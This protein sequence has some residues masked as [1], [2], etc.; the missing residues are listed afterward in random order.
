M[1]NQLGTELK[2]SQYRLLGLV[3][4]GQFGRVFCAVHRKTGRLVALKNLEQQRFSTHKFLRELRFLLSLQHRN[5]VT[6]KAL[7]H[8]ATGRYL[9]MDYCEG[10]TLRNLI[11][12]D[13]RLCLSQSLKLIADI[14]AGLEHA[15]DRSIVH[16][17]IKPENI[18]LTLQPKGWEARISDFGI[19]RLSQEI[20]NHQS[21]NTGSPAYMAPERFYGQYSI[22]SDVYSVGILLF[23]LLTGYRPFS[24]TPSELMSAH[25]NCPVKLPE[26][27]PE[28]CKP[29][30]LTALQK[31][32]ARR[33]R[34]IS[35]MRA[36]VEQVRS[37][38]EGDAAPAAMLLQAIEPATVCAFLYQH[39][40]PLATPIAQLVS[41]RRDTP[42]QDWTN[43]PV[44]RLVCRISSNLLQWQRLQ[45]SEM[46]EHKPI[47]WQKTA[48]P[49]P[50]RQLWLCPQGCVLAAERSL[51]WMP[52]DRPAFQP[53]AELKQDFL[54]TVERNG[55]W[56]AIATVPTSDQPSSIL[57]FLRLAKAAQAAGTI[58]APIDLSR[59]RMSATPQ[60]ILA[61]DRR[62]VAIVSRLHDP[63]DAN[64][65]P[66]TASRTL[67]EIF[68]RRGDRLGTLRLGCVMGSA[69]LTTEPYQL[70]AIDAQNPHSILLIDLKP[71]RV[72]RFGV[73]IAPEFLLATTWGF[74]IAN[75]QGA[76]VMLNPYGE[77]LG[78][79][80]APHPLTAIDAIDDH[81]LWIATWEGDRGSFYRIDL[82]Q[83]NMDLLF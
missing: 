66:H 58:G 48:L 3:G 40:E 72:A 75:A 6:C 22:A 33:Y 36:E 68:T 82:K 46:L 55:S 70:L 18:L 45:S 31:L 41:D 43:P 11:S 38:L 30:L 5:I 9:V 28:I 76:I 32:P 51:Y 14:L 53:I 1:S 29:I 77:C 37:A 81:H 4:Q 35:Q 49:R 50:M 12:G 80:Q 83:L 73:E 23:E 78:R 63:G 27:V 74:V 24:G 61:L 69:I 60:Q 62:H 26:G 42:L 8:T 17:D 65:Q 20:S 54:A 57:R 7:E 71:Y 34:A 39:Q 67:L 79:M 59:S 15:H 21:N 47:G 2:R 56:V 16:C 19:A 52:A 25:L 10:G 64:S 13:H 44:Q